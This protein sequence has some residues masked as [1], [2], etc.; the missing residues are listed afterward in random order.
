MMEQFAL[1]KYIYSESWTHSTS[2]LVYKKNVANP[3][4]K[5]LDK[6]VLLD[7]QASP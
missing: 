3:F 2:S 6:C 7:S 1:K 5:W 4:E